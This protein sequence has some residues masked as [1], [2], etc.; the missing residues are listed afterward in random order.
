MGEKMNIKQFV[1]RHRGEWKE[2]EQYTIHM[3]KRGR[4]V[5]GKD[6]TNFQQ[7]YQKAA[8]HLSYSQ[9]YYPNEEVTA[10]LNGLVSTSH[11]LLYKSQDSSFKQVRYFFSTKFIG[12]LLEQWKFIVIA[13][14][15]FLL[16]GLASFL[17]IVD[18]SLNFYSIM[19]DAIS[20]SIDSDRFGVWLDAID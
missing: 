16:G 3:Q 15:L 6:I 8:Q 1:K 20:S 19:L 11:N 18:R 13:M 5:T 7:L 10:Y 2:L 9:T 14:L 4:N 12:L 17:S